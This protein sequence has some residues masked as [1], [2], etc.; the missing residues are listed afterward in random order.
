MVPNF[1]VVGAQK[2]ATTSLHNY[3]ARH[4]DIY[5][6]S[7]KETKYFVEDQKYLR[8]ID[9]YLSEYFGGW[10]GQKAVGEVDPDYMYFECALERIAR[11]LDLKR[12]KVVFIFRNPVDRAFSHYLM[13]YRRG[14]EHLTF[15]EAMACEGQ[16]IVESYHS[17]MHYSYLSRGFYYRQVVRFLD[18]VDK[19]RMFFLLVEDLKKDPEQGLRLLF[20]FLNVSKSFVPVNL[21]ERFHKATVPKSMFLLRRILFEKD[22]VEKRIMR[23]LMP[24]D[25]PRL[26]L[27]S[28][29]LE[30]NQTEKNY[31]SLSDETRWRLSGVHREENQKLA[32]FIGRDL[33]HWD[34]AG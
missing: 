34:Y 26:K 21:N 24:W 31:M 33:S 11:H 30:W 12:S 15:E 20:D 1:F 9:Y 16:R 25:G 23:R 22:T 5:V 17:N 7:Q 6:P 19:T 18:Y 14:L 29:L 28:K 2:C 13:T 4:P 10:N 3:L 32:D 27:R 8:G